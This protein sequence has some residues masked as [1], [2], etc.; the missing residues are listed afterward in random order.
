M[1]HLQRGSDRLCWFCEAQ[2]S[3]YGRRLKPVVE[4]KESGQEW[5]P[6]KVNQKLGLGRRGLYL[7]V[8]MMRRTSIEIQKGPE[9][10]RLVVHSNYLKPFKGKR[11]P[12][13]WLWKEGFTFFVPS[14]PLLNCFSMGNTCW[15]VL[16]ATQLCRFPWG[17]IKSFQLS[18]I[19]C[20][21]FVL[22]VQLEYGWLS[23]WN[24]WGGLGGWCRMTS[25]IWQ[26]PPP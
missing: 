15:V 23:A 12:V 25:G 2:D 17:K 18:F 11:A 7:V 13:S 26:A 24:R 4:M 16:P 1:W 6:P 3:K 8:S 9:K 14:W 10:R 19:L 20:L 5:Y 22:S 21:L